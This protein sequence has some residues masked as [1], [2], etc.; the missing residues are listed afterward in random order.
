MDCEIF[1]R[2]F[3]TAHSNSAAAVCRYYYDRKQID[4]QSLDEL[5]VVHPFLQSNTTSFF[6][7]ALYLQLRFV[8]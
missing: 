8:I 6:S 2:G 1:C 3:L 4:S 5:V 7:R